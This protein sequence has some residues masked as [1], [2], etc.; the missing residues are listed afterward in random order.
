MFL[1]RDIPR[2]RMGVVGTPPLEIHIYIDTKTI[3]IF[4]LSFLAEE[5]K[6]GEKMKYNFGVWKIRK[7]RIPLYW[8][9]GLLWLAFNGGSQ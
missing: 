9:A 7:M 5:V 8:G 6:G 4:G 1:I 3:I 2:T